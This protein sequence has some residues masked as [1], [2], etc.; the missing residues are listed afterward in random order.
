MPCPRGPLERSV[1]L[2]IGPEGGFNDFEVEK[3]AAAG[4]EPVHLGGRILRVD[5]AVSAL[6]GRLF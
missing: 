5:A 2:A 4:L 3:L 1:T 6:L